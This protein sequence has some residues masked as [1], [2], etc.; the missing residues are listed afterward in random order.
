MKTDNATTTTLLYELG[1]SPEDDTLVGKDM[2]ASGFLQMRATF[3]L[4]PI[5]PVGTDT[6]PPGV[7]QIREHQFDSEVTGFLT[8][9]G[10]SD[11]GWSGEELDGVSLFIANATGG[12]L[13]TTRDFAHLS[14]AR[15]PWTDRSE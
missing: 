14:L 7:V 15:S 6:F 4:A 8:T 10:F 3:Q 5:N 1:G 11:T 9:T 2:S 13:T 12:N